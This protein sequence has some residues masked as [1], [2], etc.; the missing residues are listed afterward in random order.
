MPFT[1]R[2][3]TRSYQGFD[4]TDEVMVAAAFGRLARTL[5]TDDR[6]EGRR[7]AEVAFRE[8]MKIEAELLA[9]L[10]SEETRILEALL[11]KLVLALDQDEIA[12]VP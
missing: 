7:R 12:S 2:K 3:W 5:N 10:S 1:P 6:K 8:D 9:G 4:R 11:R